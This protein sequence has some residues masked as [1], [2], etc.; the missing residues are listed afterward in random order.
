METSFGVFQLVLPRGGF[1]GWGGCADLCV[2]G[3]P[4][5]AVGAAV[6]AV[7]SV[8]LRRTVIAKMDLLQELTR[9]RFK[10]QT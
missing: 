7:L 6:I 3:R 5:F 1:C 10:L 9:I 4:W 2:F 8:V